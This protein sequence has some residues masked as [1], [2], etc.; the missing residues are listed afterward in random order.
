MKGEIKSGGFDLNGSLSPL[1]TVHKL[2]AGLLDVQGTRGNAK[3]LPFERER[4]CGTPEHYQYS[5][6]LAGPIRP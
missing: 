2:L 6:T 4:P 3:A 5:T 1:Y